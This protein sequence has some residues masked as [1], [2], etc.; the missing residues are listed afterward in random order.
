VGALDDLRAA[1][2]RLEDARLEL[3][4]ALVEAGFRAQERHA[5]GA[6]GADVVGCARHVL[7]SATVEE[8]A[9]TGREVAALE[10]LVRKMLEG[11]ERHGGEAKAMLEELSAQDPQESIAVIKSTEQT[12]REGQ[13]ARTRFLLAFKSAYFMIRALQDALYR[14]AYELVE[15]RQPPD[16]QHASMMRAVTNEADPLRALLG[17]FADN[18]FQWFIGWRNLRNSVKLGRP[19][20]IVGPGAPDAPGGDNFGISLSLVGEDGSVSTDLAPGTRVSDVAEALQATAT[21]VGCV[22]LAARAT[23]R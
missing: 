5:L 2:N 22:T 3:D 18:Y 8:L 9:S 23:P 21:L 10:P 7:A 16:R 1:A 17:D 19:G 15:G 11:F 12:N 14:T 4:V 20:S 6:L 13:G